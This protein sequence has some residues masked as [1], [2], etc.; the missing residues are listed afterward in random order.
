M[1]PY[2]D[3]SFILQ[4]NQSVLD[5]TKHLG[6]GSVI[7]GCTR[8]RRTDGAGSPN[9]S[10]IGNVWSML[11]QRVARGTLPTATPDQLWQ[12]VEAAWTAVPQGYIQTSLTLCRGVWQRL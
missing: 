9:L 10:P 6:C 3:C 1:V 8:K 11:A 5:K 2:R 12:Y 7:T 4:K